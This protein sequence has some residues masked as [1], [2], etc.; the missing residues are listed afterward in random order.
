MST[1]GML[2]LQNLPLFEYWELLI[3]ESFIAYGPS[4]F[5]VT[6][7]F[8]H[9]VSP[10]QQVSK[11]GGVSQMHWRVGGSKQSNEFFTDLREN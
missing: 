2:S 8:P 11:L 10:G 3:I 9:F 7:Q 4:R 1:F 6:P 5:L